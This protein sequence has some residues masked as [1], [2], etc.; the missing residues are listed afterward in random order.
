[1]PDKP[2]PKKLRPLEDKTLEELL[3]ISAKLQEHAASLSE[4][5]RSLV[6]QIREKQAILDDR[7]NR[8]EQ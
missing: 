1:V 4:E 7:R 2:K 8:K 3:A 5:M 6:E